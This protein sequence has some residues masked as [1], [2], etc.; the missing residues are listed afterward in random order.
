M[1]HMKDET[2]VCSMCNTVQVENSEINGTI[3]TNGT[4][5]SRMD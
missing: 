5:Y 3:D 4:K 1:E 2:V